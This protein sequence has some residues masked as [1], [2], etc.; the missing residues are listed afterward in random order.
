MEMENEPIDPLAAPVFSFASEVI[1]APLEEEMRR[2]YLDYAMSVIVG[3]ALPDARDGLKPV[4]RRV[5]FGMNEINNAWNR[6]YIKC[7]RVVGEVMGKYHPH[8]DASIYDTL[9]RMAQPF[10]LRYMLVDGQGNFGSVDGDN[11]AAMRYTEARMS[12]ITHQML[13][14]IEKETVD[15]GPNYDGKESEPQV[16]PTRF[17]NLLLNGSEGIAVGMATKIPPHNLNELVA[18][19]LELLNDENYGI[20]DLIRLIPAP[21]FPT[22]GLICGLSGAADAYRTGRGSVVVRAKTHFEES[23]RGS[24]SL[25]VVDELPFQVNKLNLILAMAEL[26]KEKRIES[27]S[28]VRDESDRSGMRLVIEL[29]KGELPDVVLNQLFKMTAMQITFSINMVALVDGRPKL[30][31]LKEALTIFLSHRREVIVRR[32]LFELKKARARGHVLEGWAVALSNIDAIVAL[33]KE[34]KDPQLAKEALLG[35]V[36]SAPLVQQMLAKAALDR[37]TTRPE[38]QLADFGLS[39]EGLYQLSPEQAQEILQLRLQRLTGLE[40]DKI[41][42]EF[43]EIL[44]QI[45]DLL[46]I[47]SSQPRVSAICREELIAL[48]E[49]FG[50]ERRS[51]IVLG[52]FD[53]EDEDLIPRR[54]VMVT[55]SR[56]GYVKRSDLDEHNSQ[57][58]GGRGRAATDLK[59]A[60]AVKKMFVASS[61]DT[62]LC[63]TSAGRVLPVKVYALPEGSRQSR[64]R[65]LVNYLGLQAGERIADLL[66]VPSFDELRTLV[67]ATKLG[68]VKRTKLDDFKTIRAGGLIAIDLNDGDELVA[69]QN[70]SGDSDVMLFCVNNRVNRFA[71]RSLRTL[72]RTAK[73]VR[74]MR[75]AAGEF[76]IGMLAPESEEETLLTVTELGYAKRT[77]VG[78]YRK[79]SRGSVGVKAI[80]SDERI[81][82]LMKVM[83][84]PDGQDVLGITRA[85]V[86]IR[87][88]SDEVRK[89][90]RLAKGVRL[91]RLDDGDVLVDVC[92]AAEELPELPE[93][94]ADDL[95]LEAPDEEIGDGRE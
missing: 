11:A 1:N 6:P 35:K 70:T 52:A 37:D 53:I 43:Q 68:M 36:W 9:V 44:A 39:A 58:R 84:L 2:S 32:C 10:S 87:L 25:I 3:R 15:F 42:G 57:K 34:A 62:L 22:A 28:D 61:H 94:A 83:V 91:L 90:S 86:M 56:M 31:N 65:P 81:G 54:D 38:D 45:E 69:V 7:A 18:G 78:D 77:R 8:G 24:R 73:G 29:K 13:A 40:Q 75:L 92:V 49:E 26:V 59:D 20:D 66:P 17:P 95:A 88:S 72:S 64:G 85:G 12:K 27:I 5:L 80:P 19:C 21:D 50:D 67:F 76:I 51:E 74:C 55:F 82:R 93:A 41:V 48:R 89:T 14:D 16:L 30:L 71:E 46:D 60:D 79:A 63:F 47:I 33:I 23:E 4:H